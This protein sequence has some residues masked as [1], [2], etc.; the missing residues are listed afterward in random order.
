MIAPP[1]PP[2]K[3]LD[4][5]EALLREARARQR[6]R[7][8][9]LAAAAAAAAVALAAGVVLLEG[10]GSPLVRVPGGPTVDARA[11][12]GHGRLAF[13]SRRTL[14]VLDGADGRLRELATP[15]GAT[16]VD[17]VFSADGRWLAYLAQRTDPTANGTYGRLWIARSD[18]TGA[19]RVPGFFAYGLYGWSPRADLVAVSAGP[20]RTMQPCPCW[21][22]T[23]LRLVSP[24][25]SS[26][27]LVRG[28]WIRSA[29]WAPDGK[30]VAV[31]IED[32]PAFGRPSRIASYPVDGGRPTTWLR[33]GPQERLAGMTDV[34]LEPVGWWRGFGIGFWVFGDGATRNLDQTPLD[35][36]A[37]PGAAPQRLAETLSDGPTEVAAA[38]RS[39]LALVA[40]V[41]GGRGGGRV[42]WDEKQ[43]QVCRPGAGCHGLVGGAATVTLDPTWSPDGGTLAF[44]SAPDRRTGGWGQLALERWY[45]A[46]RLVLYDARSGTLRSVRAPGATVPEWSGDGKSLLYVAGD[47]LR[48]LPRT[49]GKPVEIASPLFPPAHWPS[50][51]AQVA[52]GAQFAWWSGR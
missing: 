26:R 34:L 49:T 19:R 44:V 41:S 50:Y 7:R 21:T 46:H 15:R 11:F 27:V 48:L 39:R 33:T 36:V 32:D 37:R 35:A 18:G 1:R 4:P 28:P 25:G 40:D 14:W 42:Y 6:R 23:S 8:R 2:V 29:A 16:P 47:A 12:S 13:V 31:G 22:P 3:T 45:G 51:F 38:Q 5:L 30:A 43:V 20:V 17:P 9:A 10:G 52:W 24:G